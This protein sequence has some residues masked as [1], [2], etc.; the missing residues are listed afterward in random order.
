MVHVHHKIFSF[1][2]YLFSFFFHHKI[3]FGHKKNGSL[4]FDVTW[5][6]LEVTVLCEISQTHGDKYRCSYSF[7]ETKK[8]K[9]V[10]EEGTVITRN[11]KKYEKGS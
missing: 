3:L 2:F 9:L 4:L 11:V 8:V 1:T 6:K 7:T 5:R 10:E